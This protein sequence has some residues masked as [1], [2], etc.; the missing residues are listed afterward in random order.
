MLLVSQTV[1]QK[2]RL[3]K[4]LRD[5][6][7]NVT[8]I[9]VHVVDYLALRKARMERIDLEEAWVAG[10][11]DINALPPDM[12]R[13]ILLMSGVTLTIPEHHDI[14]R[15]DSPSGVCR[16]WNGMLK[17]EVAH[18]TSAVVAAS[19]GSHDEALVR[20]C[21]LGNEAVVRHLLTMPIGAPR[22]DCMNGDAFLNAVFHGHT[23]IVRLLLDWPEHAPKADCLSGEALMYATESGRDDMV[24]MLLEWPKNAP[25]ADSM[26]GQAF[27]IAADKGYIV[28]A[29]LFLEWHEH[30]PLPDCFNYNAILWA[31]DSGHIDIVRM[32][33]AWP[34]HVPRADVYEDV[35]RIAAQ[36]GDVNIARLIL[37]WPNLTP[38]PDCCDGDVIMRAAQ[39]GHVEMIRML[40]DWPSH[41]PSLCHLDRAMTAAALNNQLCVLWFLHTYTMV[42]G[43][44]K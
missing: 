3:R 13:K 12:L 27:R 39:G 4:K 11:G 19:F 10:Q 40:L 6:N 14:Y 30:A 20:A 36:K 9:G 35:L 43:N 31:A 23:E 16:L 18:L 15:V 22:A 41:S 42:I 32:L 1:S 33:L 29:R 37:E 44:K 7:G 25:R 24:R 38:T 26:D 28:I 17:S 2:T 21:T 8:R 34:T 5:G